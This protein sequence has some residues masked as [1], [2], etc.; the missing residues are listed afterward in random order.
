MHETSK[1]GNIVLMHKEIEFQSKR[2]QENSSKSL[3]FHCNYNCSTQ[4]PRKMVDVMANE[5]QS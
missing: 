2:T 3:Y 1:I 4:I 5:K